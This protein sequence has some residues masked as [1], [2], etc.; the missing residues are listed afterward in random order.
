MS[1]GVLPLAASMKSP[2]NPPITVAMG[3]PVTPVTPSWFSTP[4][5]MR[6]LKW[7]PERRV[8][9]PTLVPAQMW[10]HQQLSPFTCT[11]RIG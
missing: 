1:A 6:V 9:G 8:R 11:T 7:N 5:E 2:V 10:W 3:A 4:E